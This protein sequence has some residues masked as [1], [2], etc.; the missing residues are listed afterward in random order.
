MNKRLEWKV[1]FFLAKLD[2][3]KA[4]DTARWM[5]ITWLFERREVPLALRSAYWRMH[6]DRELTFRTGDGMICF[7]LNPCRGM[8]QPPPL[9]RL[10]FLPRSWRGCC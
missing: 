10:S 1:P 4:Y 7:Q 5:A 3:A 6:F 9:I 2:I 8:P